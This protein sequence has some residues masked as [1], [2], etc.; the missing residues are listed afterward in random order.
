MRGGCKFLG[1]IIEIIEIVMILWYGR[2]CSFLALLP[3]DGG[4]EV[5]WLFFS[6]NGIIF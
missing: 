4:W 3:C 5:G 1:E 2:A 6:G